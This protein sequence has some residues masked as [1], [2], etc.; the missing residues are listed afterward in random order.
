MLVAPTEPPALRAIGT[1]SL[2]PERWGVDFFWSAGKNGLAGVQRKEFRDLI[3]SVRDGR[4][5]KECAQMQQ[6]AIPMLVVEGRP[7]WTG[8]GILLDQW[9]PWTKDQYTSLLASVQSRGI[10]VFCSDDMDDTIRTIM[11]LERWSK[12]EGHS[13]LVRRPAPSSPWG[14][15]GNRDW[16]LHIIQGLPGCGPELAARIYDEH[17]IPW[18]WKV[19]RKE[20]GSVRG[21]GPKK[22]AAWYELF[23]EIVAK[24]EPSAS[25]PRKP[26]SKKALRARTAARIAAAQERKRRP[27]Q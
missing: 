21:V 16:A 17:G 24:E 2:T 5:A 18:G 9:T 10:W 8:D 15:P 1:T 12:K 6:L 13:T 26:Q 20:L 19:T 4:L 7:K 22:V 11:D 3:A 14:K 27:V 23:D 25:E